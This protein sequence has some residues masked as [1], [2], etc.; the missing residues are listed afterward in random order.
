MQIQTQFTEIRSENIEAERQIRQQE[1]ASSQFTI[2]TFSSYSSLI[3]EKESFI[4]PQEDAT[5]SMLV[6]A[7]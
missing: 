2:S 6:T 3:F 7:S 4:L 5:H 1:V